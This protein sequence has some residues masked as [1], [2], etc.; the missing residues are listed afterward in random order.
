MNRQPQLEAPSPKPRYQISMPRLSPPEMLAILRE[1]GVP[2]HEA[3]RWIGDDP[4]L[5][6][7]AAAGH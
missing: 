3:R 2:E 6:S 1:A 5:A 7:E 4:T